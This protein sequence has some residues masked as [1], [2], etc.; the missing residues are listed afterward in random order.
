MLLNGGQVLAER[1]RISARLGAW[2]D[3]DTG[4]RLSFAEANARTNQL[5]DSGASAVLYGTDL[6]PLVE[7]LREQHPHIRWIDLESREAHAAMAGADVP[8]GIPG[9]VITRDPHLISGYW[10]LPGATKKAIRDG[11]F[12]TGDIAEVDADGFIY[13][14]DRSKDMIISGG[15]NVY[16][17][18]VEEVLHA[19]PSGKILKRVL[20][21]Q[22][23]GP[24]PE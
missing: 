19:H 20:R 2:I 13:I 12:Y 6:A 17:A 8:P 10:N 23:P 3:S 1:A 18:E 7:P 22:F 5:A 4:E 24:A 21:E 15:E 9:E 16:P 11:W 14:K